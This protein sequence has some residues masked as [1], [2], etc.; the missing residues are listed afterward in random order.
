M[1]ADPLIDSLLA[2]LDARPDDL[3]LRLH[4][5]GLLLDAGRGAEAIAQVGQALARDPGNAQAQAIMQRALGVPAAEPVTPPAQRAVPAGD[6]PLAAYEQELADVVPPRFARAGDER[7][8]VQG[9]DDRVY[10]VESPPV[11]LADVGGMAA[12]KERLELA[13]LGPLRNPELRRMYGKSLRGGLMLYGPPGCGKTFLARAVAGEMGAKFVSLSIVDVLDMWIGNS[14]RNLHELFE[15]ARRSAPCVL[16]LDE[17]DAL[18]HKRSQVSSSSMRTLGN[19]LLAELDGMEGDNEGVFV[20][21]ATNTPWDVDPALRRPGRLDRV[22]LVLPPDAEAR[23]AILEYHLRERPIANI[24][25]RRLVAATEDYSGADL[26]HL[27]ETAA[28]FAMADSVRAGVVRMIE[29]RDLERALSEVRP[30][31]RPW[32]STARNVAMFANEGGVYDDLVAYLKRR[33]LL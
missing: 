11:R 10:D 28:E 14:E 26:A 33:K 6:D 20:L 3:P 21:A 30:S 12:V 27:C 13:F 5:A 2:A 29:Q 9:D 18:G 7:E 16:F 17:I 8:P 24:D 25:L 23:A 22:V 15:A 32:L 1:S 31:T 19:Q 4:L